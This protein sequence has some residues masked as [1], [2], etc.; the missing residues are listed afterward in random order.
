M[1]SVIVELIFI[2]LDPD[3]Y[4]SVLNQTLNAATAVSDFITVQTP[5]TGIIISIIIAMAALL[6]SAIISGSE[7]A[8]LALRENDI[9]D[10]SNENAKERIRTIVSNPQKLLAAI[11]MAG[12]FMNAIMIIFANYAL[13][14]IFIA[15]NAVIGFLLNLV[16]VILLL[17][18]I[19]V[20]LP[21]LLAKSHPA[22]W[23]VAT[24][25]GISLLCRAFS[26][27]S[28]LIAISI[29]TVDKIISDKSDDLSLDKIS[30][31]LE[32]SNENEEEEIKAFCK[33]NNLRFNRFAENNVEIT[34]CEFLK[35]K[36]INAIYDALELN[37]NE[38]M[39][40]GDDINDI[41]M[42]ETVKYGICMGNGKEEA[43]KEAFFVTDNI[44]NDGLYKA[45]KH[46]EVI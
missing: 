11:L 28:R 1:L 3:P 42:F 25:K 16:I 4:L 8:Y 33:T 30:Q 26:P 20:I 32:T 36:G 6:C 44:E 37:K 35:S 17:T 34:S 24:S 43:K 38:A 5:T 22:G 14:R 23:A 46:F 19:G 18:A 15:E 29:E 39:A 21:K 41:P 40:F 13:C 9:D 45:L 31:A 10:I 12:N 27:F 2:I 7:S